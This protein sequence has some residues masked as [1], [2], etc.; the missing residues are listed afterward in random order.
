VTARE[1]IR[2]VTTDGGDRAGIIC[3]D[4]EAAH[5][6]AEVASPMV[7]GNVHVIRLT[8]A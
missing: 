6:L 1:G 4:D 5:C 2:F 8:I 7:S 3:G